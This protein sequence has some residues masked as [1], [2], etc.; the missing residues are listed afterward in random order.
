MIILLVCVVAASLMA[1]RRVAQWSDDPV[2]SPHPDT[3]PTQLSAG[4]ETGKAQEPTD[5][6][7]ATDSTPEQGSAA[8]DVIRTRIAFKER[9]RSGGPPPTA[10]PG[11]PTDVRVDG[12]AVVAPG[13]ALMW[14][15]SAAGAFEYADAES[16]CRELEVGEFEDW[17]LP[18]IFEL[19]RLLQTEHGWSAAA[20]ARMLWSST[21]D[22]VR[23]VETV[24][25][26]AGTRSHQKVGLAHV[27]C[28]RSHIE[29]S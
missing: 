8:V 12:D 9:A 15:R 18:D 6:I 16:L 25:L 2:I 20:G 29:Q 4:R 21:P 24:E 11:P 22:E 1:C 23:G 13:I 10:T 26:P 28:V 7:V 3:D 19:E 17:R 14:M 5:S 27:I